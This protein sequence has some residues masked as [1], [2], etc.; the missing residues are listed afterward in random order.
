MRASPPVRCPLRVAATVAADSRLPGP[1]A[2][3]DLDAMTAA[4][5][6]DVGV[7]GG[8]AQAQTQGAARLVRRAAHRGQHM[9]W[10]GRAGGAGRSRGAAQA[11]EVE[12]VDQ[13]APSRPRTSDRQQPR[14]P[15]RGM[16]GQLHAVDGQDAP[17]P[18]GRGA[19]HATRPSRPARPP[20]AAMRRP[21]PRPRPRPRCRRGGGAPGCRHGPGAGWRCRA[22]A[23]SRRCPWGLPA[24]G[25]RPRA[26]PRPG[27]GCR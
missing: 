13:A 27:P 15:V 7:G 25:R 17:R 23:T 16:A 24:C 1:L 26:G 10:L 2:L 9:R 5:A 3:D 19:R 21:C 6:I 4:A 22:A 18:A 12:G 20:P 11:L 8:A 14:Q